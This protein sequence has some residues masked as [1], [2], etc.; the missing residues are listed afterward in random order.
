[1][2]KTVPTVTGD[3]VPVAIRGTTVWVETD[4]IFVDLLSLTVSSSDIPLCV[5]GWGRRIWGEERVTGT[6]SF[7]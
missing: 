2:R 4:N 3:T 5:D 6:M 1:M 7:I